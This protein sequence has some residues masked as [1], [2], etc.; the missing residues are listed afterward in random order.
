[1]RN[2][3]CRYLF[4]KPNGVGRRGRWAVA[5][6]GVVCLILSVFTPEAAAQITKQALIG[7][8]VSEVGNRYADVDEAIKRFANRDFLGARQFLES[9]KRK[10][11]ALPPTDLIL[12]KM[13]FMS[14]NAPAGRASL[15]K[16][17]KDN[18]GDPEVYFMLA[19]DAIQ[20]GRSIE[21]DA[22]YD[23]GLTMNEKFSEN[24][25]R[26]R[27]LEIRG[28]NGRSLV[29]ERRQNWPAAASDLEA[30]LKQDPE[31]ATAHY[32]LGRALFMQKKYQEGF[33]QF[34]AARDLDKESIPDPYVAAGLHYDLLGDQARARQA[35]DRALAANRNDPN[36]LTAYGQWLIK[37]GEVDKAEQAL[38]EARKSNPESLNLLILSGVAARMNKKMKPAED[39]FM[40]ALRI[41]PA[42]GD[43]INQL[44]QLLIEQPEQ[45]KRE[46]ALQF[47]RISSQINGQSADAHVTLAWVLYQV[48]LLGDAETALRKAQQLGTFSPDSSF[49]IAKILMDQSKPEAAKQL[50]QDA[51]DTESQGIFV[52][53]RDAEALLETINR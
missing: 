49:L 7:D 19:D 15:E 22:L 35:F 3:L 37:T 28:R 34:K 39:F 46:R 26:K 29:A 21:A 5:I 50:L 14:G 12:A 38:A 2:S 32:R 47:A 20:N 51:L 8:A 53:R 1:M 52:N 31:N 44:A 16:T 25:R 48:G 41:S 27:I 6:A 9:A 10:D 42:N 43:V 30:L 23:K 18:P 11:A 4:P 24:A 17:A 36:A 33:D 40:E 45:A 13:Y